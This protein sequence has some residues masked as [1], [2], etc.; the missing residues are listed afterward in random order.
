MLLVEVNMIGPFINAI[1]GQLFEM[2]LSNFCMES[3]LRSKLILKAFLFVLSM[4]EK[5]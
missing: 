2:V 1:G 4:G 5:R 3:A